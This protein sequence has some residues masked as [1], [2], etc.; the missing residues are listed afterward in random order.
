MLILDSEGLL[1]GNKKFQKQSVTPS[2]DW[3]QV[4]DSKS[5]CSS[6]SK[7]QVMHKKKFFK[8]TRK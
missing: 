6:D 3:T 4:S 1:R 8:D 2:A 5:K 7:N